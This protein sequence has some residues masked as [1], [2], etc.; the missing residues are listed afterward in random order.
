M[1][2]PTLKD[3]RAVDVA[4][5]LLAPGFV[6]AVDSGSWFSP[7]VSQAM[8][9]VVPYVLLSPVPRSVFSRKFLVTDELWDWADMHMPWF[10]QFWVRVGDGPHGDPSVRTRSGCI[11]TACLLLWTWEPEAWTMSTLCWQA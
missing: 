7:S 1:L 9:D 10:L 2:L 6:Y 5:A 4:Q 3:F 8:T 11:G